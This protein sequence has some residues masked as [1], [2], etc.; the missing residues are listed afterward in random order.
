MRAAALESNGSR[1][2]EISDPAD[3]IPSDYGNVTDVTVELRA[4]RIHIPGP[5]A[6][7]TFAM[8]IEVLSHAE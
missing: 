8:I 6:R 5:G 2:V 3:S 7:E 4:A 1:F